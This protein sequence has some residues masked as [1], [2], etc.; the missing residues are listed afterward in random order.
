MTWLIMIFSN[1]ETVRRIEDEPEMQRTLALQME[2]KANGA[3]RVTREEE[4]VDR[5]R[6][7]IRFLGS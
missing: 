7:D 2:Y 5:K 1:R 4:V 6:T 3:Y